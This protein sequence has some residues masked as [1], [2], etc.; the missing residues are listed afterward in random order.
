MVGIVINVTIVVLTLYAWAQILLGTGS[1]EE[2]S[3][4]GIESLKYYTILS[5]LLSAAAS[6]AFVAASLAGGHVGPDSWIVALK[7]AS[8]TSV[9]ITFLVTLTLLAPSFGWRALYAGGNFWLHLVL[10]LLALLDLCLFVPAGSSPFWF[11]FVAVV[12]TFMYSIGYVRSVL[13][14]GAEENGRVY[15]F[16]GF[17]RWGA[18]KIFV[19]A[20]VMLVVTFLIA[21]ALRALSSV[22]GAV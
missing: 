5:N 7:L 20:A 21:L 9:M 22:A 2:L 15:D 1:D 11:V 8:T 17:M 3:A 10:P 4:R 6:L 14:H 19:V 18:D 12:P 16:Y 13:V